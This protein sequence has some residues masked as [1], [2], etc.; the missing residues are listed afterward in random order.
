MPGLGPV[1]QTTP[2]LPIQG[3]DLV[4]LSSFAGTTNPGQ[5]GAPIETEFMKRLLALS[6]LAGFSLNAQADIFA[7]FREQD[8]STNW[9]YIANTSASLL[10]VTLSIVL[11]FLI[12]AN[13]RAR[14]ANRALTEIKATLEE[15]VAQR[16]AVLQETTGQLRKR[17]AYITSIVNSMPV[18]LIGLNQQL[19]VTQ[20]NSTAEETTGRPF[21]DVVGQSLW[22]AYPAITLK[23]EQVQGVLDSGETLQ[24]KHTQRGQYTFD[25]TLYRLGGHDDAGIVILISDITK[26]VNAENKVAERDKMSAL[27]ELASAMAYDINLPINTIRA[28]AS[29]ARQIIESTDLD[30]VKTYLLR[31]ME[32]IRQSTQQATAIAQNLLDLARSHRHTEQPADVAAIMDRSIALA[33][34]LFTDIDG[35]AFRDIEMRRDYDTSL[36]LLSCYPAELEQVFVRLLRSAFYAL[37]GKTR[38]TDEQPWI[39][40]EIGKFFDSVWIKIL[41]KGQCLSAD[42]QLDIFEPFFAISPHPTACPVEQRLS[43]PYFIITEHHHGHLSVTSEEEL[44]TCFNIQLSLV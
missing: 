14:R 34:A 41:H 15:R 31:E 16:T 4:K 25:I 37:K 23:R 39:R 40:A 3:N 28:R 7:V 44:G 35:L 2:E 5:R 6:A 12:R 18:M 20:W 26:Q 17:E 32:T 38:G 27:G 29:N 11:I 13:L 33:S 22:D 8:G 9:Q 24:L 36:P 1:A 10:I 30:P 19:Q 42:E 21:D 43:Y